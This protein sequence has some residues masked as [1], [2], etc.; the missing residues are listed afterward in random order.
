MA[1]NGAPALG[2]GYR[3]SSIVK[4]TN[5]VPVFMRS[6]V[7][8]ETA[9]LTARMGANEVAGAY[10]KD[11]SGM[12]RVVDTEQEF[13]TIATETDDLGQTHIK[14]QADIQGR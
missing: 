4:A 1:A 13:S 11:I 9:K 6:K 5:G 8:A 2:E 7:T 12:L 10:L 14:M 3:H